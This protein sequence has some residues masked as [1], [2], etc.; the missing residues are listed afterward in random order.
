MMNYKL[1]Y[2]VV[3]ELCCKDEKGVLKFLKR[4]YCKKFDSFDEAKNYIN[5]LPLNTIYDTEDI[6]DNTK[7]YSYVLSIELID[8]DNLLVN[9]MET[10]I[11]KE[12]EISDKDLKDYEDK[13]ND[14]KN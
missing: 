6:K 4:I 10:E 9:C 14:Y 7:F 12:E 11:L 2:Y 3:K 1:E 8:E 13:K 5:G